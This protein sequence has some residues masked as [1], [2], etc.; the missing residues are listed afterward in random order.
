MLN[1]KDDSLPLK[2]EPTPFIQVKDTVNLESREHF[3]CWTLLGPNKKR[4][5]R[6]FMVE[7]TIL[8]VMEPDPRSFPSMDTSPTK[9]KN[10]LQNNRLSKV[11]SAIVT[12]VLPLQNI[13]I[14]GDPNDNTSLIIACH[15]QTWST[16]F[17]FDDSSVRDSAI[18]VL[19]KFKF[20]VRSTKM[21]QI[22]QILDS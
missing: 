17:F 14:Q 11:S 4:I 21:M 16:S 12:N 22:N 2:E 15:P 20:K 19:E 10:P 6:Y 9:G 3:S 13:E 7:S 1:K 18:E 8:L 5:R